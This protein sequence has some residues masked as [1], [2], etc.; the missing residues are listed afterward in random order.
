M[1]LP[2][3]RATRYKF[4]KQFLSEFSFFFLTVGVTYSKGINIKNFLIQN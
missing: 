3:F 2:T 1:Y 4:P